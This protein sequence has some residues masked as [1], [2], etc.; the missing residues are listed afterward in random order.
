[1][2]IAT[3]SENERGAR[4]SQPRA[5]SI[6]GAAALDLIL[7]LV[8]VLIGRGSHAEGFTLSGTLETAWPFVAGLAIGWLAMRAWRQPRRVLRT[9]VG[10]WLVT[11]IAGM[12]L[13]AASGQGVALAFV[14]VA[15]V[16]LAVF[17]LGWRAIARLVERRR[18]IR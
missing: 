1:M 7:V 15:T 11:V 18:R 6:A 17:L 3:A 13:R 8:F 5:A 9:G 10:I 12:L 16:V 2:G 14:I 4:V